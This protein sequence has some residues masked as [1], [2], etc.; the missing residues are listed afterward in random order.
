MCGCVLGDLKDIAEEKET[1]EGKLEEEKQGPI[2]PE[3]PSRALSL[4]SLSLFVC[5]CVCVCVCVCV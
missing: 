1:E 2:D 4:L 5:T 3:G